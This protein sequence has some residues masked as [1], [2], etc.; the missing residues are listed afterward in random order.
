MYT[1][2]LHTFN[3]AHPMFQEG[4]PPAIF[5]TIPNFAPDFCTSTSSQLSEIPRLTLRSQ[6]EQNCHPKA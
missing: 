6:H 5:R 3:P 4:H 2:A 1:T